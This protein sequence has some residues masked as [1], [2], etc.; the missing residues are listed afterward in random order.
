MSWSHPGAG[1]ESSIAVKIPAAQLPAASE[2][3][4]AAKGDLVGL[5]D[6]VGL[7]G[8]QSFA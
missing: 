1:S 3:L 7:D 5:G 4:L 8:P 2:G 6:V